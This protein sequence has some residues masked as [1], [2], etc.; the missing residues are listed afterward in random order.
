MKIFRKKVNFFELLNN[1]CEIMRRGIEALCKYC[2]S[3][4][5]ENH[6]SYGDMVI[7]IEDECDMARHIVVD[8]LN[9][10][11]ITPMERNDIFD[12]SSQL[13]DIIDY[14]KTTVDEMRIFG[15][16]PNEDMEKMTDILYDI[17]LHIQKAVAN[18][19]KHKNIARDE[20]IK[21]RS[22]ENTMG[23][24]YYQAL[25]TLFESDD[26]KLIFKYR[27]V[28]RHLNTTADV[29]VTAMNYLVDIVNSL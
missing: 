1:Q 28:Y 24:A 17:M 7:A 25:A 21:V 18:I 20:A 10:T 29:A 16:M 13:D 4:G 23:E 15:I 9:N 3:A 14:A 27:E 8:E 11:F 19:E 12:L 5:D 6:E 26:F 22:L 2:K